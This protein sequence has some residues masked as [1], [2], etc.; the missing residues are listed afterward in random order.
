MIEEIRTPK[1]IVNIF[2]VFQDTDRIIL[3]CDEKSGKFKVCTDNWKNIFL[4][5]Y[6]RTKR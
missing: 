1:P 3:K 6:R 2:D 4:R 5:E